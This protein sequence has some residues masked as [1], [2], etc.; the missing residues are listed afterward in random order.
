MEERG[1]LIRLQHDDG[2]PAGFTLVDNRDIWTTCDR[3]RRLVLRP[4]ALGVYTAMRSLPGGWEFREPWLMEHLDMGRDALR[5]AI[6]DL[7]SADRLT[8]A[9][10]RDAQ[11]R[12][13]RTIWTLHRAGASPLTGFPSPGNPSPEDPTAGK[14]RRRETRTRVN[15]E[16]ASNTDLELNTE[17]ITTTTAPA[18]VLIWPHWL[19]EDKRVVVVEWMDGLNPA[20]Q[21]RLL[22]EFARKMETDPPGSPMGWLFKTIERA[23]TGKDG[24]FIP[25]LG[26]VV[27]A[28]RA[29]AAQEATDEEAARFAKAEAQKLLSERQAL[30]DQMDDSQVRELLAANPELKSIQIDDWLKDGRPKNSHIASIARAAIGRRK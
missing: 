30:L 26:L 19:D 21:Q 5:H 11:G 25:S 27:E 9:V 22:D 18:P 24:G 28:R 12:Y 15:K 14:P 4:L 16:R 2:Y 3:N 20:L 13:V 1:Q 6:R 7:E 23:R 10:Q 29:R 17:S 8:R